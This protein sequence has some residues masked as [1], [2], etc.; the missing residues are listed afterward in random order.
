MLLD[1][2]GQPYKILETKSPVFGRTPC[3]KCGSVSSRTVHKGFARTWRLTCQQ[4]GS[5]LAIGR[6]ELPEGE[7]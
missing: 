4:C 7:V 6:G 2:H 1:V 3:G 5:E